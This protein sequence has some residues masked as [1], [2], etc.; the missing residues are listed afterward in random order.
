M[1]SA[2]LVSVSTFLRDQPIHP[3]PPPTVFKPVDLI[4]GGLNMITSPL[5]TILQENPADILAHTV[6][7]KIER[8][9]RERVGETRREERIGE[10]ETEDDKHY[11]SRISF[12]SRDHQC[13]SSI[14]P[15]HPHLKRQTDRSGLCCHMTH[16]TR[17]YM[18]ARP[19]D[20]GAKC[21]VTAETST[22]CDASPYLHGCLSSQL[23]NADCRKLS[24]QVH[25]L[26]T[27]GT[28]T[29]E[30]IFFQLASSFCKALLSRLRPLAL[31][32]SPEETRQL[33]MKMMFF[34]F[35]GCP[36]LSLQT[37]VSSVTNQCVRL[38]YGYYLPAVVW[39][40]LRSGLGIAVLMDT[41]GEGVAH[42]QL[43]VLLE[44]L[45]PSSSSS[46]AFDSLRGGIFNLDSLIS[47]RALRSFCF[48]DIPLR[49]LSCCSQSC[50]F[51][52][53]SVQVQLLLQPLQALF[54]QSLLSLQL[55]T[56]VTVSL[57]PQLL[58]AL[59]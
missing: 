57:L 17:I 22:P 7:L 59:C 38:C 20:S 36:T 2:Q 18:R 5:Y 37:L 8:E 41:L 11:T 51:G 53:L 10:G 12:H 45:C 52:Y 25:K 15:V 39:A 19:P 34:I 9:R 43:G 4:G 27:K 16:C 6:V 48:T 42:Q 23:I 32:H 29:Q 40:L 50:P 1:E 30:Q 46:A 44:K 14:H 55:S 31:S 21:W 24:A 3:P 56:Q 47:F 26:S 28:V 33:T 13:S 35:H 54:G 58:T 49:I